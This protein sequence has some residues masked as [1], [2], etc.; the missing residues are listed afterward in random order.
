M[1]ARMIFLI[2]IGIS[3]PKLALVIMLMLVMTVMRR[4]KAAR[5]KER[6]QRDLVLK[7]TSPKVGCQILSSF[8]G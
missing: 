1:M 7:D 4:T 5:M 6:A 8:Q 3:T 2:A